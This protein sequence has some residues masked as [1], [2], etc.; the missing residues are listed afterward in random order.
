MD[1]KSSKQLKQYSPHSSIRLPPVLELHWLWYQLMYSS[2]VHS[3]LSFV[4]LV[5]YV[6]NAP[7]SMGSKNRRLRLQ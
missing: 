1:R 3:V 4:P 5:Y 6:L 7:G 2:E